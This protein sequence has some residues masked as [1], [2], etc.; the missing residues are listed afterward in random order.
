MHFARNF[1]KLFAPF[2][3]RIIFGKTFSF[4]KT[5]FA[6]GNVTI[7]AEIIR[8]HMGVDAAFLYRNEHI[9]GSGAGLN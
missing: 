1:A 6:N 3:K 8:I 5:E 2:P 9:R 7:M 4:Y